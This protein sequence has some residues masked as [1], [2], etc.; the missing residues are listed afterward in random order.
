MAVCWR[1]LRPGLEYRAS[2]A[3]AEEP[4]PAG[5]KS[6]WWQRGR[7]D[8]VGA[9]LMALA[10]A[11]ITVGLGTGTQT[12]DATSAATS[13]PVQ[14]PWLVVSAVSFVAFILPFLSLAV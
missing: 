10:L 12:I 1:L 7:V 2:L 6:H 9:C 5:R 11:G 14:W 4:V 13:T 3:P 8:Y